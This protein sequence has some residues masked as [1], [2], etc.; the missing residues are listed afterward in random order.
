MLFP[1]TEELDLVL[2]DDDIAVP[3]RGVILL[4]DDEKVIRFTGKVILNDLGYDVI[5]AVNGRD[6]LELYKLNT[7]S[8]DLVILDMIM[9]EM[10]GHDC[11]FQ[12]KKIN[13]EVKILLSS[14][15]SKEQDLQ[16]LLDNGLN[17]VVK[18]PY[19]TSELSRKIAEVLS[20]N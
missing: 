4:A 20:R 11:F 5:T 16:D 2:P 8:I 7:D 10:N 9:P 13:P 1:V 3:G 6:A 14:G 12:L 17:G 19:H 15:F 18:K